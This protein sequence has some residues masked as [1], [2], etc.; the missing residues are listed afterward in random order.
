MNAWLLLV[1][2]WH[3]LRLWEDHQ[4]SVSQ[5]GGEEQK[6]WEFSIEKK[7]EHDKELMKKMA[8]RTGFLKS[9]SGDGAEPVSFSPF[10]NGYVA[11]T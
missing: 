10:K 7:E 5:D 3:I 1:Q 11:N 4:W 2:V 6:V 8:K 9:F